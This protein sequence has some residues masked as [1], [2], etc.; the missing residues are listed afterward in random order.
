MTME[1]N[2]EAYI[3]VGMKLNLVKTNFKN[4]AQYNIGIRL[5]G[6]GSRR[7]NV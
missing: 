1:V 6:T 2:F 7:G 3:H 5:Y 4:T